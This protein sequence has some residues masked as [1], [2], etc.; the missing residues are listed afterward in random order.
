MPVELNVLHAIRAEEPFTHR[1]N[2]PK[3]KAIKRSRIAIGKSPSGIRWVLGSIVFSQKFFQFRH[4]N[5][6]SSLE[7]SRSDAAFFDDPSQGP[8]AYGKKPR[9]FD[10]GDGQG[11]RN[12]FL[13]VHA[14]SL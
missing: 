14:A 7:F 11:G 4:R 3:P 1:N 12:F 10:Y 6:N 2:M 5:Q 9:G 8:L 13:G